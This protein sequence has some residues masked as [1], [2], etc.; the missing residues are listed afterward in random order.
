MSQ[1]FSLKFSEIRIGDLPRVG[2]KNASLGELFNALVPKG[3]NVLDGFALT[4][5]HIGACLRN[6]DCAESW[7][8]FLQSWIQRI[9]R[10]E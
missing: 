6:K 7:S 9:C 2:G 8:R 5:A 3:V 1:T 10:I 4:T